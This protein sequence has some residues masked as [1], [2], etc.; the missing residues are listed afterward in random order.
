M[1]SAPD[2][3]C[4]RSRYVFAPCSSM[5]TLSLGL[6]TYSPLHVRPAAFVL[7]ATAS[8]DALSLGHLD[9]LHSML[10]LSFS[11]LEVS[12]NSS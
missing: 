6:Q 1:H 4:S 9:P 7:L 12:F 8:P 3:F 5:T 10:Q 2:S 11:V